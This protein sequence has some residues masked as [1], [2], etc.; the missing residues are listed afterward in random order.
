MTSTDNIVQAWQ[1]YLRTIDWQRLI[2]GVAPKASGCGLIYELVNP[3]ERPDEDFSIADMRAIAFAE[4]H[5]HPDPNIEIY[6]VLEGSGTMVLGDTQQSL[7]AGSVVVIPPDTA[8]FTIPNNLV[9][10]VV[11][12]PP[13]KPEIYIPLT[14]TDS[15]VG[16]NYQQ[17][18]KLTHSR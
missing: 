16:F 17:F 4:P 5:F 14:D 8:H 3:L 15:A 18:K 12:T 1:Q 9:L 2:Q 11:N 10:A 6:F 7:A 13:F